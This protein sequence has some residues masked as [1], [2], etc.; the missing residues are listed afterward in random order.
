MKLEYSFERGGE[1]E[2]VIETAGQRGSARQ[3]HEGK[4]FVN[5][6]EVE[7]FN[8]EQQLHKNQK[9]VLENGSILDLLFYE[10]KLNI[11]L[12]DN[13]VPGANNDPIAINVNKFES[14]FGIITLILFGFFVAIFISFRNSNWGA[15]SISILMAIF[16]YLPMHLYWKGKSL[17]LIIYGLYAISAFLLIDFIYSIFSTYMFFSDFFE[18]SGIN[19][20]LIYLLG[21]GLSNLAYS[22]APIA[23][24]GYIF[25]MMT[26]SVFRLFKIKEYENSGI[27]WRSSRLQL[28]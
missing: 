23:W 28:S 24:K 19:Q 27:Q 21:D 17:K 15:V 26:V 8:G 2:L 11:S 5:G 3:W 20:G 6:K 7:Q 18:E 12:D 22:L 9:V 13:P 14:S 4:I 10:G 25:S 1:K 16:C